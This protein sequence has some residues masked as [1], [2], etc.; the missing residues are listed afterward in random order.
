TSHV[1][2]HILHS[3]PT[4]RS[5]DLPCASPANTASAN[6]SV[7]AKPP[8]HTNTTNNPPPRPRLPKPTPPTPTMSN[9]PSTAKRG[10]Q[11]YST[12]VTDRKSTRLNSSHQI[13]SYAVF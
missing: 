12:K 5:S 4:R 3:L 9:S 10:S 6:P 13:I 2:H 11:P 7:T 8:S 1:T